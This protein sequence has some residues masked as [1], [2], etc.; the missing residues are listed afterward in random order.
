MFSPLAKAH[1]EK[2]VSLWVFVLAIVCGA[3]AQT[4][5]ERNTSVSREGLHETT[6]QINPSPSRA[7]TP[8]FEL[9]PGS[10]TGIDLVHTFPEKA[11]FALLQD[12][13]AGTGVCAGDYDDDGLPD[14][15]ITNYDRGNRLYRN[16][17][18]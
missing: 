1:R 11:P 7:G 18:N 2:L 16:L 3:Q 13:G 5:L 9:M 10:N 15:F 12:Q 17:G 4:P 6:L 8:M 14:L